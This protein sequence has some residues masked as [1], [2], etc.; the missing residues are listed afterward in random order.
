MDSSRHASSSDKPEHPTKP[1]A[2]PPAPEA[3]ARVTHCVIAIWDPDKGTCDVQGHVFSD[4]PWNTAALEARVRTLLDI[5]QDD[6]VRL[7]VAVSRPHGWFGG[8]TDQPGVYVTADSF[9]KLRNGLSDIAR[10]LPPGGHLWRRLVSEAL[11]G[12]R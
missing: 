8:F 3:D 12:A 7:A 2:T 11:A 5:P 9:E 10:N 4:V 1:T 6:R